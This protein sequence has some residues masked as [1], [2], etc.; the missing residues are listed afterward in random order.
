VPFALPTCAYRLTRARLTCV[1]A[2]DDGYAHFR[3]VHVKPLQ[4]FVKRLFDIA[5]SG[6]ALVA[7]SPLLIAAAVLVKLTSRGP[8]LFGRSASVCT[9]AP[10]M[11]KFRSMVANAEQLRRSSRPRTSRP[12]RL[13]DEA[14]PAG[15]RRRAVHGKHSIDE[16]RSS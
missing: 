16:L 5:A 13:Q 3:S 15:D 7:L 6:A 2:K 12:D 11:L 9:G 4:L 10:F 14:R 8:V 1:G